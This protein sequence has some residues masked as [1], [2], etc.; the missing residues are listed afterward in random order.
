MKKRILAASVTAIMLLSACA[1]PAPAPAPAPAAPAPAAPA[2]PAPEAP[3]DVEDDFTLEG[4]FNIRVFA[5]AGGIAD[6]ITRITAQNLQEVYGITPIISNITGATGAIAVTDL[7][8]HAPSINELAVVPLGLFTMVPLMNPELNIN[9][10]D[11]EIVG[12]LVR[13]EF[14]LLVSSDSG[15][16]SWDDLV[17]FGQSNRIIYGSNAP[18]GGTHVIQIALFGEA[19]LD[20]AALTSD[21]SNLDIL[22]VMSGDAHVTAATITLARTFIESGDLVPILMFSTNEF[23]GFE[24]F[25]VPPITNYGFNITLPSYNYLVTRSGVPENEIQAFYDAVLSVRETDMFREMA[26]TAGYIPDDTDGETLRA[27][28][29]YFSEMTREIFERFY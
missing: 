20:A 14:V 15:I 26:E 23:S 28:I 2:A 12:S 4:T 19:E 10:D 29:E 5:A 11:Y 6:T 27:R 16:T 1:S 22:A 25:V 24:G 3:A 8:S 13:D 17:E 9:L 18:G 21:G 7:N